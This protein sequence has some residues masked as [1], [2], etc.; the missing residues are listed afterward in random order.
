MTISQFETAF[1]RHYK[2]ILFFC[3]KCLRNQ[4]DAEDTAMSVFLTLFEKLDSI[5]FET[6]QNYLVIS[7]RNKVVDFQRREK[8]F[9]NIVIEVKEFDIDHR[10]DLQ[11]LIKMID[12][13]P[14]KMKEG[15]LLQYVHGY[16]RE[17]IAAMLNKSPNTVRNNNAAAMLKL[18]QLSS[19]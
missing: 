12:Q 10:D 13:L 18:R 5:R 6:V 15:V 17:E 9:K 1:Q 7:A 14:E 4:H 2:P 19:L 8:R 3:H 11:H 16:S